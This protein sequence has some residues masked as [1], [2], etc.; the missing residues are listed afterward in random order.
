MDVERFRRNSGKGE[1]VD[2]NGDKFYFKP[3]PLSDLPDLMIANDLQ[4]KDGLSKEESKQLFNVIQ[5][6][7]DYCFP[8]LEKESE[9][10]DSFIRENIMLIMEKMMKLSMPKFGDVSETQKSAIEKLKQDVSKK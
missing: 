3:L 2:I 7:V 8:E 4:G 6:Y 10:R 5:N 9:L 1:M